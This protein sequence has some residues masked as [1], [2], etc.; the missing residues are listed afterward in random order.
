M[1][2]SVKNKKK[3]FSF[4]VGPVLSV[5]L[6]LLWLVPF[7]VAACTAVLLVFCIAKELRKADRLGF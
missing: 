4:I 3:T 1:D 7:S 2:D 5:V 6:L